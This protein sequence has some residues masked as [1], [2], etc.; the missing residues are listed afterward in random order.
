MFSGKSEEL[1]RRIK[2][3]QIARLRIKVFKPALD[4]RF[5]RKDICSHSGF[6]FSAIP[7]AH[8]EEVLEHLEDDTQVVG[9]DEVQFFPDTIVEVCQTMADRGMRVI[10]AGLDQDFKGRPFGPVPILLAVA[11]KIDKLQAICVVCGNT[12]SRSQ[13]IIDGHPASLDSPVILVGASES[14]EA[15]CRHCHALPPGAGVS[16]SEAL[17]ETLRKVNNL[18]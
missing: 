14:Y 2:R 5:S 9:I 1:I 13:R 4:D 3:A 17:P 6:S 10:C 7:V 15:R 12:A 16:E 11:E 18:V 8:P